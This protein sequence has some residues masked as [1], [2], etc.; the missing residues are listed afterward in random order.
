MGLVNS[1][2]SGYT[3]YD[4][5]PQ[6]RPRLG[7]VNPSDNGVYYG[8]STMTQCR[9]FMQEHMLLHYENGWRSQDGSRVGAIVF[10]PE[11]D[12]NGGFTAAYWRL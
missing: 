2:N 8:P 6:R 1:N 11:D 10:R 5:A 4:V 12:K 9:G 3:V 7:L